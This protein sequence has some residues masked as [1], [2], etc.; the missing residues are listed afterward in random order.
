MYC[1]QCGYNNDKYS[2]MCK[3]CGSLLRSGENQS[4]DSSREGSGEQENQGLKYARKRETPI[5][6]LKS[7]FRRMERAT[8]GRKRIIIMVIVAA[9]VALCIAGALVIGHLR[10]ANE[11]PVVIYGNVSGNIANGGVAVSDDKWIFYS[12]PDG[13]NPGLYRISRETGDELKVSYICLTQMSLVGDWLYGVDESGVLM[14]I[15]TDGIVSEEVISDDVVRYANV[16][17]DTLYYIG[18]DDMIYRASLGGLSRRGYIVPERIIDTP[19][20]SLYT[21]GGYLY[22]LTLDTTTLTPGS[23]LEDVEEHSIY[24]TYG[25]E[26]PRNVLLTTSGSDVAVGS[27]HRCAPDGSGD[28]ALSEGV[29]CSM[30][31]QGDYIY[32]QSEIE[33]IISATDVAPKAPKDMT[34]I[35]TG[36]QCWRINLITRRQTKYMESGIVASPINASDEAIY[37]IGMDGNLMTADLSGENARVVLTDFGAVESFSIAGDW[38]YYT[39]DGGTSV[40]RVKTD[41]SEKEMLC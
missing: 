12:L 32:C 4:A 5:E 41:G 13:D 7:H 6:W 40:G 2:K 22:Y 38:I 3:R 30:T 8:G 39:S 26:P 29:M 23:I 17:N 35:K 28:V 36:T 37:F 9:A 15:S 25:E 18:M 1:R 16:V 19:A 34:L 27:V 10:E 31:V 20:A 14:R 24:D 33:M 21:Y 11:E